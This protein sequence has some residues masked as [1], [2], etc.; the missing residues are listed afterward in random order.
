MAELAAAAAASGRI[1]QTTAAGMGELAAV[2]AGGRVVQRQQ[3]RGQGLVA[4]VAVAA[5]MGLLALLPVQLDMAELAAAVE[6]AAQLAQL[7]WQEP[8][9]QDW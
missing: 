6:V 5:D 9:D 1:L 7:P 3:P 8:Q 2:V 4:L